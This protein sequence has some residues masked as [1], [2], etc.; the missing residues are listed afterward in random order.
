MGL[1]TYYVSR[2]R[3][4]VSQKMT[5]ADEGGRG[6]GKP[7]DDDCWRGSEIVQIMEFKGAKY[8]EKED[9]LTI[10]VKAKQ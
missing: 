1:F 9:N 3:G 2:E 7:K 10:Y 4:G 6:G 5:I 8:V